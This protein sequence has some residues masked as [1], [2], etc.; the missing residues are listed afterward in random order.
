M[1]E[2]DV[3]K[4]YL[5][6]WTEQCIMIQSPFVH[7]GI[8]VF[9]PD[10]DYTTFA[11]AA[12]Q[13]HLQNGGLLS[14][15]SAPSE[16]EPSIV[17]YATGIEISTMD[18]DSTPEWDLLIGDDATVVLALNNSSFELPEF[19]T[20]IEVDAQF[21]ESMMAAWKKELNISNVSQG[22]YVSMALYNEGANTR[23]T[24]ASDVFG[25]GPVWPPRQMDSS[26]QRPDVQRQ[27]LQ[28]NGIV[29]SWTALSAAGAPS[30]FSL[31]APLLEGLTTVYVRLTDGP[32]GVFLMVDD[33]EHDISIGNSVEFVIRRIYGQESVVRYGL[34][35]RPI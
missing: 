14:V 24:L 3:W 10:S 30:E 35:A 15:V 26:G 9:G 4:G 2:S 18:N 34:K 29:E 33:E 32:H 5:A 8:R 13:L 19:E 11:I 20:K 28:T 27:P 1:M 6:A 31:R 17:Q 16:I 7:K 23:M 21:H 22:A 12:I 25:N